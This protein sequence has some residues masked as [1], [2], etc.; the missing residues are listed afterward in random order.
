MM[1]ILLGLVKSI[2]E[3]IKDDDHITWFHAL[4]EANQ[5]DCLA[6]FANSLDSHLTSNSFP[7]LTRLLQKPYHM[8]MSM[9]MCHTLFICR[10]ALIN[11]IQV[12]LR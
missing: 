12:K 5:V 11:Q 8:Y 3:L 7:I 1:I 4:R 9:S 10:K 2:H 6:N